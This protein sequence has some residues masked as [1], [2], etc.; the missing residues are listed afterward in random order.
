MKS[1]L[2]A[3]SFLIADFAATLVFAALLAITH[4]VTLAIVLGMAF[5][6][7]QIAWQFLRKRP[8]DTMQWMGLFMVLGFGT[9]GLFTHDAR[10]LMIKP[11]LVYVIVGVVMLKP[12]WMTRYLPEIVQQHS[13]D[14]VKLFG[15]V[16]AGLMFFSAVLN[17]VLALQ[18]PT[19]TWAAVM[20]TYSLA[21]KVV[22]FLI[23][24][25]LMRVVTRRRVRTGM[26]M[27]QPA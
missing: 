7:G 17:I 23:Q 27:A 8:V 2:S 26:A 3:A 14:L 9:L 6:V 13:A 20:S 24:Y 15:Y 10:F 21:S 22:L 1:L 19:L 16:W 4:S 11:S 25:T 12:G 18:L 5:G